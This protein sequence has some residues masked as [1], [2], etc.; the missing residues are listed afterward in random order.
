MKLK[1]LLD[2]DGTITKKD[3]CVG[4]LE[5]FAIEGWQRLE[6]MWA[7]GDLTTREC[8]YETFKLMK[9]T[10]DLLSEYLKTLNVDD[11][12]D[13]LIMMCNERDIEV[14][15]VSDGYNFNINTIL[16]ANDKQIPKVYSNTITFEDNERYTIGFPNYNEQC[17]KCGTCKRN[18]YNK[19]REDCDKIIYAGDGFSD[20]CPAELADVL[21]AKGSLKKYCDE[22]NISYNR[23]N[24][25]K[26]VMDYIVSLDG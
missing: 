9:I 12:F 22:R 11:Y 14:V 7:S 25:F 21:F 1:L 5:E 23:F 16:E 3:T 2:F 13:D 17:G 8:A 15:I 18:I 19:Y 10:R 26:D 24:N 4:M 20:R 6:D